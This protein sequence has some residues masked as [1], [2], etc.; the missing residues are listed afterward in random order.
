MID[1]SCNPCIF[2]NKEEI[3]CSTY[4]RELTKKERD[5]QVE[6]YFFCDEEREYEE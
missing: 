1:I 6:C 5:K 4:G 3:Y 2:F